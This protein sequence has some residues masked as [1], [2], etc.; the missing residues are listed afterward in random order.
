[1]TDAQPPETVPGSL[2]RAAWSFY[3]A[4]AIAGVVWIGVRQGEITS[5][6]FF[7]PA[8]WWI[9]LGLG[10]G[11]G[12]VLLV[13][14]RLGRR[15]LASIDELEGQIRDALRGI[16][17]AEA[18]SLAIVSGFSE[19]LFFR[20]AL[21]ASWGWVWGVVIFALLHA[22]P[23]TFIGVWMLYALLAG[24]LFAQLTL[25]RG[26]IAAAVIAHV[27]VNALQLRRLARV[28]TAQPV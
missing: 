23:R 15:L 10:L 9:D 20:G 27:L 6:L 17:P 8:G 28:A 16:T 11:C 21:Q 26:N 19:E 7:D 18:V 4:L 12:A 24:T 1:M 5:G 22:H 3:L 25:V 2:Y 14:W 13:S